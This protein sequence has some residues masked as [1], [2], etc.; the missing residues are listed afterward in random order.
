MASGTPVKYWRTTNEPGG[1]GQG[2]YHQSKQRRE[3]VL[4]LT[5][6]DGA[7]IFAGI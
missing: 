6:P 3:L 4:P 7:N 1:L 5:V 2:R